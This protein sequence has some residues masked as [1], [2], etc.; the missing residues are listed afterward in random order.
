MRGGEGSDAV[1]RALHKGRGQNRKVIGGPNW[2]RKEAIR[3]GTGCESLE[4]A[5]EA[6]ELPR[7]EEEW[8][9]EASAQELAE[10][11]RKLKRDKGRA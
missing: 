11:E 3:F 8:G 7:R 10:R 5:A 9:Q 4:R 1:A 2:V 6:S